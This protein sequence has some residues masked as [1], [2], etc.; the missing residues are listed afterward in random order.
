LRKVFSFVEL[1]YATLAAKSRRAEVILA[2]LS[3]SRK[4]FLAL[5]RDQRVIRVTGS[6]ASV[7]RSEQLDESCQ[8]ADGKVDASQRQC[9]SSDSVRAGH[10]L[11]K[12]LRL[13][14]RSRE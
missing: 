3:S 1:A 13:A 4:R 8:A 12:T 9:V 2:P 7:S 5:F 14:A 6:E 11:N 10:D